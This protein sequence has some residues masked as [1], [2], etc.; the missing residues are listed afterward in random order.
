[1]LTTNA[2]YASPG[3]GEGMENTAHSATSRLMPIEC[4]SILSCSVENLPRSAH[5][6]PCALADGSLHHGS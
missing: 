4:E 6:R 3:T 5:V 2:A 1:M